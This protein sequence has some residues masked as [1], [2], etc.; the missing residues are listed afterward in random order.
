MEKS[1]E[2]VVQQTGFLLLEVA[3]ML[4]EGA[5]NHDYD[6]FRRAAMRAALRAAKT[7]DKMSPD[8]DAKETLKGLEIP[9]G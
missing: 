4:K 3:K 8:A 2:Y 6:K 1:E 7:L 9:E 5:L